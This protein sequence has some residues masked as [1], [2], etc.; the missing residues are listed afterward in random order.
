MIASHA[1]AQSFSVGTT[2]TTFVDP[3]RNTRNI[4]CDVYYP[5]V[6]DGT[7]TDWAEGQFGHVVFGHGFLMAVSSYQTIASS[8]AA[9]GYV[10]LLPSTEGGLL[11]SHENFGRDLAFVAED[12]IDKS[13]DEDDFYFDKLT[14]NFAIGGHSM[15]GGATYLSH[16]FLTESANCFFTFAAAETNPSSTAAVGSI[17]APNLFLAGELDCVTPPDVQQAMY[18][19]QTEEACK[20]YVEIL[21][22]FH[23]QFNDPSFTCNLG[24]SSCS[25]GGGISL[26][27]QVDIVLSF[28][29][30]W[31]DSWLNNGCEEWDDFTMLA[32]TSQDIDLAYSC[33]L[34]T[35]T[36]PTINTTGQIPACPGDEVILI[37]E[38]TGD[39][40]PTW[41]NGDSGVEISVSVPGE[42]FFTISNGVCT[43]TSPVIEVTYQEAISPLVEAPQGN[44]TCPGETIVLQAIPGEGDIVWS[45]GSTGTSIEV[46]EPGTYTFT[47]EVNGCVFES[48][49]FTVDQVNDPGAMVLHLQGL[50]ICGGEE[51][52]LM[53]NGTYEDV[54]WSDG[55]IGNE[56]SVAVAGTYQFE[57][58]F[59][60]CTFAS[61]NSVD[62]NEVVAENLTVQSED[63]KN[64]ICPGGNLN[65]FTEA[66][67]EIEWTDFQFGPS[68]IIAEGGLYSFQTYI[69]DCTFFSDTLE[70]FEAED[71]QPSVVAEG[72][73]ILCPGDEMTLSAS[74]D[75]DIEWSTGETDASITVQSS[76]NYSYLLTAQD[77]VYASDTIE[78]IVESDPGLK[79]EVSG[80]DLLLCE[81]DSLILN[82]SFSGA[83][84]VWSDGTSADSITVS[85]PGLYAYEIQLENCSFQSDTVEIQ[86]VHELV[87]TI[88]VLA[89][90]PGCE[91]DTIQLMA[92][93]A[94][95]DIMWNTGDT[96]TNIQITSPG[97]YMFSYLI[98]GCTFESESMDIAFIDKPMTSIIWDEMAINCPGDSIWLST[99]DID[100]DAI[101]NDDVQ[102]DSFLVTSSQRV[103]LSFSIEE[104]VFQIDDVEVTFEEEWTAGSITGPDSVMVDM[105]YT[106]SVEGDENWSYQ[107]TGTGLEILSGQGSQIVE[108][109]VLQ[110]APAILEIAVLIDDLL[111]K[112]TAVVKSVLLE[113]SV[114]T[115]D[116]NLPEY[117]VRYGESS[118]FIDFEDDR[119]IR[120]LLLHDTHGR[121]LHT[122]TEA[123]P[124]VELQN[125]HL[126]PGMYL[127]NIITDNERLSTI[128]LI[129]E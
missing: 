36:E 53:T 7:D 49:P 81:G 4:P 123:S 86:V 90:L 91:G 96:A 124:T 50:S 25:P 69:E 114:S 128:K 13:M 80:G 44:T 110:D 127:L 106:F 78:V 97:D 122:K 113:T 63:D 41:S 77:C 5:A 93:V 11:P 16:Q 3:T 125:H 31:L 22:G 18:D 9:S 58:T 85:E 98:D 10:V 43:E 74:E 42:Y 23:C 52:T 29:I 51:V 37:A 59:D 8:L 87:A 39:F 60:N 103:S 83:G 72:A 118:W 15:G 111:C 40:V 26:N 21:G 48:T 35:L 116:V 24:E 14:S 108:V 46:L 17:T 28:L 120:Q 33:D 112:D 75:G 19:S 115:V 55:Q 66:E 95:G 47:E 6:S 100:G 62:I 76:G 129:K 64:I 70:V 71:L 99:E 38:G 79:V 56:I 2:S 61:Q 88:D 92:E 102:A 89:D 27:D 126:P 109:E 117:L 94:S 73:T 45:T 121:I 105:T 1:F 119:P 67:G 32:L 84:A 54:V 101:W 57:Y 30:P 34:E 12:V 65:L 107:W 20:Y 82:T 68:I 104:C